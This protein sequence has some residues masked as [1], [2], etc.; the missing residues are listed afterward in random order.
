M[1]VACASVIYSSKMRHSFPQTSVHRARQ[2]TVIS[3]VRVKRTSLIHAEWSGFG[4][5]K[6]SRQA[7]WEGEFTVRSIPPRTRAASDEHYMHREDGSLAA[8]RAQGNPAS[9]LTRSYLRV[10][11]SSLYTV[12]RSVYYE[13]WA[14]PNTCLLAD[15]RLISCA[16]NTLVLSAFSLCP[17]LPWPFIYIVLLSL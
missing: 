11:S 7:F 16:N 5:E 1:A 3:P 13:G 9:A 8:L 10:L 4:N 15:E 2:L 6:R 14:R 12:D 17:C